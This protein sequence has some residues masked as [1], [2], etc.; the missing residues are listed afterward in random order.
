MKKILLMAIMLLICA[1]CAAK[2][3]SL[4]VDGSKVVMENYAIT[5]TVT[6]D[7]DG[8]IVKSKK[9][10]IPMYEGIIGKVNTV[11]K[12]ILDLLVE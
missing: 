8:K 5:E 11:V 3:D 1:G 10:M 6:Y 4:A 2:Y 7:A 12:P 9:V